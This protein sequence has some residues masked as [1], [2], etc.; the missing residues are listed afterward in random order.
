MKRLLLILMMCPIGV[1]SFAQAQLSWAERAY[2]YVAQDS[3]LQAEECFEQAVREA[4]TS[5][6]RA[7]LLANLGTVQRR[8][9]RV[10]ESVE[11]YTQALA[12][13][14]LDAELL[15]HRATAYMALG[16]DDKA[17]VDLCNVLDKEKN[18]VEAL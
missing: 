9:G 12:L 4:A 8:R 13:T 18:H 7:M 2:A 5:E 10:R 17:Y 15:M 6:Q 3:L 16:N 11:T 1:L 14:P